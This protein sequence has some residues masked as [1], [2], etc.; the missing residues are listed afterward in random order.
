MKSDKTSLVTLQMDIKKLLEKGI[1]EGVFPAAA[2]GISI[3]LGDEK[4]III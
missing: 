4:K 3:G 1:L 2:A